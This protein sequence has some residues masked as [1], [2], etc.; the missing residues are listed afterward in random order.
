[1]YSSSSE[2]G[3]QVSVDWHSSVFSSVSSSLWPTRSFTRTQDT[4][5]NSRLKEVGYRQNSV[6]LRPSLAVSC[7]PS[8]SFRSPGPLRLPVYT[9]S[10][11]SSV[12]LHSVAGWSSSSS[13]A[14]TTSS[15]PTFYTPLPS[16]LPT[17]SSDRCSVSDSLSLYRQCS[18]TWASTG[19]VLSLPFWLSPVLLYLCQ[20][21]Q[22]CRW[23]LADSIA[24]S[25]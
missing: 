17:L 2:D 11:P 18:K 1:M 13:V 4:A 25:T 14:S 24:Y 12:Q 23:H 3:H 6:S 9:G 20:S 22:S 15:T 21:N 8:V 16:S 7:F 5:G 10:R 19:L